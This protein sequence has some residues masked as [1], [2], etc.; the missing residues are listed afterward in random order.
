MF[1]LET[2]MEFEGLEAVLK[3]KETVEI[4][5]MLLDGEALKVAVGAVAAT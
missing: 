1:G 5:G 3:F 2:V 4:P